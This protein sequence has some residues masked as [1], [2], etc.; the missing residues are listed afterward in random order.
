MASRNLQYYARQLEPEAQQMRLAAGLMQAY[1]ELHAR[2]ED[3]EGRAVLALG[4]AAATPLLMALRGIGDGLDWACARSID[5]LCTGTLPEP[6]QWLGDFEDLSVDAIHELN[7]VASSE[8]VQE[9]T[10]AN[11]DIRLL[12]VSEGRMVAI[13]PPPGEQ[14]ST[15][16]A[17]V[18]TFIEGV[19]SADP[20]K[21]QRTIDRARQIAQATGGPAIAWAGYAAP[22]GLAHGV[23]AE[24]A[25]RAGRD[26]ARFQRS[27]RQRYPGARQT[28]VG[29]SYG[30]VVAGS[31]ATQPE[32][33]A[34]DDLVLLGSPGAVA[35]SARDYRLH[36]DDPQVHSLTAKG[37][38]IDAVAS[39]WGGIHG[40]DPT[41]RGFGARPWPDPVYGDHGSYFSD[42]RFF[43][44]LGDIARGK[45]GGF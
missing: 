37:D 4:G 7:L 6:P 42:P 34:A 31:A 14:V 26:L 1:A 9:F 40:P 35:E 20:E 32:G 16:P 15:E 44:H 33:L 21:W 36:G 22:P 25:Q 3:L 19:G 45:E 17:S 27:L 41:S 28:V 39:P 18:T 29:Y 43:E 24:P 10:R 12:E 23:H 2:L 38:P 5:A 13:V 11:P 8:F 30:S